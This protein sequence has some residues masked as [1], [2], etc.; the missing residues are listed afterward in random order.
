MTAANT[1]RR[2]GRSPPDGADRDLPVESLG[3]ILAEWSK[4]RITG[5]TRIFSQIDEYRFIRE[6]RVIRG[7]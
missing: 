6:I 1:A 7:Q 3:G 4:P 5:I 2:Q